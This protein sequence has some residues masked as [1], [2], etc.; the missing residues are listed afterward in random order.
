MIAVTDIVTP[1]ILVKWSEEYGLA[2]SRTKFTSGGKYLPV[3]TSN[4]QY[5]GL[6]VLTFM[7]ADIT[8]STNVLTL[9]YGYAGTL[10]SWDNWTVAVDK[11]APNDGFLFDNTPSAA[12]VLYQKVNGVNR[13]IYITPEGL[14]PPDSTESLKP[15]RTVAIW[16]QRDVRDGTMIDIAAVKSYSIDMITTDAKANYDK[17]GQW[18]SS[19][20]AVDYTN[21]HAAAFNKK[22]QSSAENGDSDHVDAQKAQGDN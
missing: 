3:A 8:S 16:F 1:N 14:L 7:A 6:L 15:L 17:D 21:G 5:P 11:R 12:A 2:A 4:Y 20:G 10:K 13:P 19:S 18:S 22:S 9:S